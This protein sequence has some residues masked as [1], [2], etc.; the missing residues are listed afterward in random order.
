MTGVRALVLCGWMC[1]LL[2][3]PG[4]RAGVVGAGDA[5]HGWVLGIPDGLDRSTIF[6]LPPRATLGVSR[7][8]PPGTIRR[9]G[10]TREAPIAIAATGNRLLMIFEPEGD[11]PASPVRSLAVYPGPNRHSWIETPPG[12]LRVERSLPIAADRVLG[13]AGGPAGETALVLEQAPTEDEPDLPAIIGMRLLTR[14]GWISVPLPT[15]EDRAAA[16]APATFE[17]SRL[18]DTPDGPALLVIAGDGRIGV[19][20]GELSSQRTLVEDQDGGTEAVWTASTVWRYEALAAAGDEP[21]AQFGPVLWQMGRLI[22][23]VRE[24]GRWLIRSH[25]D[26]SVVTLARLPGGVPEQIAAAPLR[27]TGTLAVVWSLP[28]PP[29]AM[30]EGT[31]GPR[32]RAAGDIRVNM[33]ELSVATGA[34]IRDGPPRVGG[35]MTRSELSTLALALLVITGVMLLLLIGGP[36]RKEWTVPPGFALAPHPPRVMA[37][38]IDAMLAALISA[39]ILGIPFAS[40]FA[41]DAVAQDG[42]GEWGLLWTLGIAWTIGTVSETLTGRSPGKIVMGLGVTRVDGVLAKPSLGQSAI[43]NACVWLAPQLAIFALL[44]QERRHRGDEASGIVV[45]Q[46]IEPEDG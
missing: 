34:I 10:T 37:F 25:S 26:Q 27:D 38:L 6:H 39:S 23:F 16:N 40:A 20:R 17:R 30:T 28:A 32:S 46:A 41:I 42:G 35:L 4:A 22:L 5:G 13:L 45:V 33:L 29:S 1:L 36:Q 21:D 2:L 19:W 18:L 11:E 24:Q 14:D 8:A 12:R 7:G 43:R 44:D 15:A 3:V 9:A 31:V